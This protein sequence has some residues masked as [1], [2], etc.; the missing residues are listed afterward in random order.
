M[1]IFDNK[2]R[3]IGDIFK[4]TFDEWVAKDE[5]GQAGD[6]Y[7]NRFA[8][9]RQ[10]NKGDKKFKPL[11]KKCSKCGTTSGQLDINHKDGN[12]KNNNRSNLSY[13]C[14]SCHRKMH[15]KK[16]GGKGSLESQH[17][18]STG[19]RIIEDPKTP[20]SLAIAN[21]HKN[22][23]LMFIEFI[24]CHVDKNENQDEFLEDDLKA[25][26]STAIHKPLNW[27]HIE[28]NNIGT[29]YESTYVSI[30]DLEESAK[31]YYEGIDPLTTDFVVVKACVW[32]YKYPREARIMR[33]RHAEGKLFFSMENLMEK[34]KCS[35]CEEVFGSRF[36]YCD[37][38]LT[39]RQ[40]KEST[41][42]F[43]NSNFV[44][45]GC[46]KVPADHGAGTLAI[47]RF[48]NS[49]VSFSKFMAS[50][51]MSN[52]DI[53]TAIIPYIVKARDSEMTIEKKQVIPSEF[54]KASK[55][56]E[57]LKDVAFAD[58]TNRLFPLDTV[59]HTETSADEILNGD[60]DFYSNNEK[61]IVVE[62]LAKAL[63]D[64]D[65]E[66]THYIDDNQGGNQEMTIDKNSPEFKDAVKAAVAEAIKE[67]ESGEKFN[68]LEEKLTVANA[69][70]DTLKS[71]V[72]TEK[73]AKDK[74]EAD[75]QDYKDKAE[76]EKK[77]NARLASLE[78]KGLSFEDNK[79]FVA[80]LA[81]TASDEDFEKFTS[82]LVE[83]NEAAEAKF[84]KKGEEEEEKKPGEKE[85]TP[86]EKKKL[87]EKE[88]AKAGKKDPV[89]ESKEVAIASKT[90]DSSN[91][92]DS[93]FVDDCLKETLDLI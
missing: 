1:P 24:L 60:L 7:H 50:K 76:Q 57:E 65:L 2:K 37:H 6:T 81:A 90:D 80:N 48:L 43:I 69:S 84:T 45:A 40:T 32:E 25:S 67:I 68:E 4:D 47:A 86:E 35:E 66:I 77:A 82:T 49:E 19:A 72:E 18:Y 42:Q 30:K 87:K 22:S 85:L 88:K 52:I 91:D 53:E 8:P 62:K 17:I 34:A 5:L 12:R 83:L 39:R 41:R 14:R 13:M 10:H 56:L 36:D 89:E 31:A 75:F 58:E 93:N 3:T 23:D 21:A 16:N 54:T 92:D 27:E 15:A 73:G 51:V 71:E 29:I 55:D 33:T 11:K 38:L 78:E 79:E 74:A 46:V 61:L 44:G 63:N 59:E 20:E 26:A 28:T 70:I 64:F 9:D